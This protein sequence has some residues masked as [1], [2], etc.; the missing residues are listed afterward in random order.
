MNQALNKC[1]LI[2]IVASLCSF[3]C[4]AEANENSLYINND[5]YFTATL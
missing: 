2:V 3:V 1:I 4:T 5:C